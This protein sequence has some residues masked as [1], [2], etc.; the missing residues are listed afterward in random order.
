MEV[1]KEER[2]PYPQGEKKEQPKSL[3]LQAFLGLKK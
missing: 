2:A 3:L 1:K